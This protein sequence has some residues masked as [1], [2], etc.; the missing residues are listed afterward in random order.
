MMTTQTITLSL[1]E[2]LYRSA[3][4]VA[5][6]TKQPL[7]ALL[8]DSIARTLPPLDDVSLEEATELA[9]LASLNDASLW[10]E[11]RATM[12]PAEQATM[13]ELLDRQGGSELMPADHARLQ[14]LL[15]VYGRLMVRKAH[16]YL[17]LARRGYRVPM[18]ESLR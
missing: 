5:E 2:P 14:D 3:R 15:D 8:T 12:K 16:A 7:E 4:Q 6:A 13:H 1:P 17:L 18:Q 9:N 11:A 10:Q